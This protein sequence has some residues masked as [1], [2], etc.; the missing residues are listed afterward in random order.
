MKSAA[1]TM[2]I[3]QIALSNDV[4][5]KLLINNIVMYI[6]N[7]FENMVETYGYNENLDEVD[8]DQ[9]IEKLGVILKEKISEGLV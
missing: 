5:L 7:N 8:L 3:E 1:I 2:V 4:L 9:V 6:F